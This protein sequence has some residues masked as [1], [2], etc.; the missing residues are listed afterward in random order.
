MRNV[1]NEP[2]SISTSTS[3]EAARGLE[4]VRILLA[5]VDSPSAPFIQ[6]E[7]MTAV[8]IAVSM[9]TATISPALIIIEFQIS[10]LQLATALLSKAAGGMQKRYAINKAALSGL[11]GLL[12]A[13]LRSMADEAERAEFMGLLEDVS[14]DLE[15]VRASA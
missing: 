5:V 8:T 9:K 12:R 11:V 13:L 3:G 10:M 2:A 14:L 15:N 6:E 4:I 7:W 1:S